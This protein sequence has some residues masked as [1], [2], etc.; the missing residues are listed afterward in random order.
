MSAVVSSDRSTQSDHPK[1]NRLGS[2]GFA[3]AKKTAVAAAVAVAARDLPA[4]NSFPVS[5]SKLFLSANNVRGNKPSDEGIVQLAAMIEAQGLLADL[6]VSPELK[7][8]KPTGRYGVEAG[9]RRWRALGLLVKEG[10]LHPDAPI[11]CKGVEAGSETIVSLTENISVE[12]MHPVDEFCAMAKLAKEGKPLEVIAAA[13]GVTVLHVQ[14]RMKL[15]AVAPTLLDLYRNDKATLDQM[16]ALASIDDQK[17]QVAVW[18]S[19]PDYGRSA[20]SI[21]RK[22]LEEEVSK[23]DERVKLIGLARYKASGGATRFDLFSEMETL[24]DPGLVD[25]IVAEVLTERAD[26]V[27]AEGYAWVETLPSW[28]YGE[29]ERFRAP[30]AKYLPE[31]NE[32]RAEREALQAHLAEVEATLQVHY[33]REDDNEGAEDDGAVSD[34]V[35]ARMHEFDNLRT[36]EADLQKQIAKLASGLID[37]KGYP[38]ASLG[39]VVALQNGAI[40]VVRDVLTIEQYKAAAKAS[41]KESPALAGSLGQSVGAPQEKAEFSEKLMADLTSHRTA[42]IQATM[43]SQQNVALAALA[44]RLAQSVLH[45]GHVESV[46]EVSPKTCIDALARDASGF[47]GSP[48]GKLLQEQ[49][50]YWRELLPKD[51]KTWFAFLL[52]QDSATVLSLIVFCTAA[53]VNTVQRRGKASAQADALTTALHLD[54]ADW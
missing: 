6:H 19:L 47:D 28:G 41:A 26:E 31:S 17:R 38:K 4:G 21:K 36:Q 9:G 5:Y 29:S 20:G 23:D 27:R 46:I 33:D 2:R 16:M 7:D 30:P 32:Q 50:A 54:M 24:T 34:A 25:L 49:I 8:G 53:S 13:F 22:L 15:A 12:S 10:K 3:S 44:A 40:K 39:A 42:A 43:L 18:K 11:N 35:K 14:R 48:A 37:K 1:A 45:F 52:D 51:A